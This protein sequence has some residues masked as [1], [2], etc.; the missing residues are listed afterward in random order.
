MM[1]QMTISDPL[2]AVP[3]R[4]L[5]RAR[6]KVGRAAWAARYYRNFSRDAVLRI[7]EAVDK[8]TIAVKNP[9]KSLGSHLVSVKL[10]DDVSA[11]V[12]L[13]VIPA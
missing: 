12:A 2:L 13:N 11:S 3:D 9:I 7:A 10:H 6:M 8:R 1:E 5:S 4:A